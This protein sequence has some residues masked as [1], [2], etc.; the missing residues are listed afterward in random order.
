M[1][2]LGDNNY[3]NVM[4]KK[5]RR[6]VREWLFIDSDRIDEYDM[7]L[8]GI[9]FDTL[10]IPE[11]EYRPHVAMSS[12]KFTRIVPDLSVRIEVSKEGVRFASEEAAN[13]SVSF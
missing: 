1:K 12:S 3:S 4:R 8:V 2:I 11:T 6:W 13:S 7:K 10:G 5:I 9:D